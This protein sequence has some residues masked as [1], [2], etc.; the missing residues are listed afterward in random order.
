[1]KFFEFL[2]HAILKSIAPDQDA[3][4]IEVNTFARKQL[5]TTVGHFLN[6]IAFANWG[7]HVGISTEYSANYQRCLS[8]FID[9]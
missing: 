8:V 9:F 3:C 4:C 5:I 6:G 1:M 7:P 2:K